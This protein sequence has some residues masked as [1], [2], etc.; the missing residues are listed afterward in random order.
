MNWIHTHTDYSFLLVYRTHPYIQIQ[1]NNCFFLF[2]KHVQCSCVFIHHNSLLVKFS[3]HYIKCK[4]SV[5]ENVSLFLEKCVI[6][7]PL[8]LLNSSG[9]KEASP[10]AVVM[11]TAPVWVQQT[12]EVRETGRDDGAAQSY[13]PDSWHSWTELPHTHILPSCRLCQHC[14]LTLAN[15]GYT[16]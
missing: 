12:N 16:H 11:A 8:G 10:G 6:M 3:F 14:Q 5:K 13:C 9:E 4:T 7:V 15:F 1:V 2:F